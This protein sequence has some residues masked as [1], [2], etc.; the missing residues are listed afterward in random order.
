MNFTVQSVASDINLMAAMDTH[1][2]FK[3][4]RM[5]GEIFGLVHDSIIGQCHIEE[6]DRVKYAL[7][8]YTQIDR[9]VSIP[10]CPIGLDFGYGNTYA[11]AA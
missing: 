9:G 10:G 3:E 8:H 11:E 7:K 5:H 6:I 2:M 4:V 1:E